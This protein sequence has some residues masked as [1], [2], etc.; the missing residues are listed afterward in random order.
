[1]VQIDLE[2]ST[3]RNYMDMWADRDMNFNAKLSNEV[4]AMGTLGNE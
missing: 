4:I 3:G 1:M 2:K